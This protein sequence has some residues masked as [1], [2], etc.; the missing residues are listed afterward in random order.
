MSDNQEKIILEIDE[1]DYL[2]ESKEKVAS[3]RV[4][5]FSLAKENYCIQ[6]KQAKE[7]INLPEVTPVPNTP[8][9]ITGVINLRGEIIALIDPHYFLG[10]AKKERTQESKVI[11]T[12]A[13]GFVMGLLVDEIDDAVDIA[14]TLIQPPLATLNDRLAGYTKGNIQIGDKII[15]FLDLAK[16][17]NNS[18]INNLKKGELLC[19][20]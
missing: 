4:L 19:A 16:V 2:A 6:I 1:Q 8:E 10:L 14:E 3:V 5:V 17:L 7:V 13:P 9:F 12:D 18:E 20:S 15:I 11:V